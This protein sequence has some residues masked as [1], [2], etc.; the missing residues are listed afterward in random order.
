MKLIVHQ[1]VPDLGCDPFSAVTG[2]TNCSTWD[3]ITWNGYNGQGVIVE[4][5]ANV[6]MTIDYING[7]TNLPL[8]DIENASKG[9]K[10]DIVRPVPTSGST[11]LPIYW[12]DL[13]L[14]GGPNITTGCIYPTSAT[15]T[16]CHSFPP[17]APQHDQ[18]RAPGGII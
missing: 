16:G 10:V 8:W 2:S 3:T 5:G 11:I 4:I 14:G 17:N 13:N 6:N 15:V 9:I 7:L 12:D 1:Q 18:I